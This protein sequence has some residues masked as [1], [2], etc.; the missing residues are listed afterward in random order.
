MFQNLSLF[1]Q[2][3]TAVLSVVY[4]KRYANQPFYKFLVALLLL[5]ALVE[6]IGTFVY[7]FKIDSYYLSY[8]FIAFQNL[9]ALLLFRVLV[10]QRKILWLLWWAFLFVWL[11]YFEARA[12]I[13]KPVI[14]GSLCIA[15]Y[16]LWY[17]R[18]LLL[19]DKILVYKKMISFWV[20]V[21]FLIFHLSS[22]PFF[23]MVHYMQTRGLFFVLNVLIILMNLLI[24]FGFVCSKKEK[25]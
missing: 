16:A 21:A 25:Y 6:S 14:F 23:S 18:E 10:G 19:S 9:L 24:I 4:L 20:A 5:I 11:W 2:I 7:S 22:V 3:S 1:F 8:G 17:L 13:T 15:V 12:Q